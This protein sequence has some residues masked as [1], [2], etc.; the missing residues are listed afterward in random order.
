V[1]AA[2]EEEE[3]L[4]YTPWSKEFPFVCLVGWF[5]F[6]FLF[7]IF[8]WQNSNGKIFVVVECFS[9]C[10]YFVKTAKIKFLSLN[11]SCCT[12]TEVDFC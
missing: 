1:L 11:V 4:W 12:V 8:F 3:P 9:S 6:L 7:F 5:Y 2:P 10:F